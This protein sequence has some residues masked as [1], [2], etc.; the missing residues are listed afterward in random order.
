MKHMIPLVLLV[1]L[2]LGFMMSAKAQTTSEKAVISLKNGEKRL[3]IFGLRKPVVEEIEGGIKISCRNEDPHRWSA[4]VTYTF[5][6]PVKA[7]SVSFDFSQ[8]QIGKLTAGCELENGIQLK[9]VLASEGPTLMN[10]SVDFATTASDLKVSFDD[11]PVKSVFITFTVPPD[12]G[13]TVIEIRNWSL[14]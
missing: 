6:K 7:G 11:A 9:Q 5:E 10:Y 4:V 1:G 13:D 8:N 3:N 2:S 14:Q 12:T